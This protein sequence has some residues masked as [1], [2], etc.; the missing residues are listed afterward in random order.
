RHVGKNGAC[1]G[2]RHSRPLAE[3]TYGLLAALA[4]WRFKKDSHCKRQKP[5]SAVNGA[6]GFV[7]VERVNRQG[8]KSAKE[9]R[10]AE[11]ETAR[12]AHDL[13]GVRASAW[14]RRRSR[15]NWNC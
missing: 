7:A 12:P 2:D 5:T 13:G 8:A 15:T 1:R 11:G 4:T 10:V 14:H 6:R 3:V 9:T